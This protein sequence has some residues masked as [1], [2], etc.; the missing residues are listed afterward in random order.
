M[1]VECARHDDAGE[2]QAGGWNASR[3]A[4][5]LWLAAGGVIAEDGATATGALATDGG[6]SAAAA[7]GNA[8][9]GLYD[10]ECVCELQG[11]PPAADISLTIRWLPRWNLED[12]VAS[13]YAETFRANPDGVIHLAL[14]LLLPLLPLLLIAAILDER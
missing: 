14:A 3:C 1:R 5:A 6:A 2:A 11:S 12:G 8:S 10:V 4:T 13:T 7:D 9:A